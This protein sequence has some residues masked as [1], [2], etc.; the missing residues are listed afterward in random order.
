MQEDSWSIQ[1]RRNDKGQ[2]C[3]KFYGQFYLSTKQVLYI[4]GILIALGSAIPYVIPF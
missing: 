3:L 4:L 1:I 2:I